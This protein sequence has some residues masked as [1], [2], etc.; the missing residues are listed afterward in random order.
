MGYGKMRIQFRLGIFGEEVL[1][2]LSRLTNVVALR[3]LQ[4]FCPNCGNELM[5][6][7]AFCPKC[8]SRVDGT[9]SHNT[10]TIPHA[11]LALGGNVIS[12]SGY[13]LKGRYYICRGVVVS[14]SKDLS[15]PLKDIVSVHVE[16]EPW[17][18]LEITMWV[19][20]ILFTGL[21][22]LICLAI[23][24]SQ[25][26]R[27]RILIRAKNQKTIII[28]LLRKEVE[29]ARDFAKVLE[30]ARNKART[31]QSLQTSRA[32]T[33]SPPIMPRSSNNHDKKTSDGRFIIE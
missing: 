10:I 3:S 29:Q 25:I 13:T 2:Y 16:E 9:C 32:K 7:S 21:L 15:I 22:L 24:Q 1:Y 23:S 19:L 8:G 12:I 31:I 30:S 18:A 4:M 28:P 14:A 33:P 27:F 20:L 26:G 11:E 17:G 5:S 6:N